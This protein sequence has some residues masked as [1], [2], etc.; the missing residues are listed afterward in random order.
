MCTE[1]VV[2]CLL[3]SS[4]KAGMH[5]GDASLVMIFLQDVRIRELNMEYI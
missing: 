2:F 3:S 4:L 1:R 5:K